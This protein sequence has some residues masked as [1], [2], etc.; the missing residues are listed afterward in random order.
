MEIFLS[1]QSLLFLFVF[2]IL[3]F[4]ALVICSRFLIDGS[5]ALAHRFNISQL[6]IGTTIIGMGTSID[7]LIVN[8]SS[9]NL[10]NASEIILGNIL[11]SNIVNLALGIGIPALITTIAATK[12]IVEKEIPIYLGLTAL[13]TSFA[14]DGQL[15]KNEGYI[16]NAI[17]FAMLFLIYQFSKKKITIQMF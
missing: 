17:F 11:G 7:E 3:S 16:F 8:M 2:I 1:S 15:T 4:F 5:V 12:G 14:S 13:F 9:I 10:P 6:I